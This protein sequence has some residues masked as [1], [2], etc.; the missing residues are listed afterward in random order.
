MAALP[1]TPYWARQYTRWF[2]ENCGKVTEQAAERAELLVSELVTNAVR[3]S[4]DPE[5]KP[6]SPQSDSERSDAGIVSLSLR[7]FPSGLLIEVRDGDDNPPVLSDVNG[8]AE[9]G[10]G[11]MLVDTLA[12]EWSY[13]FVADGGK[14]VYC[15]LAMP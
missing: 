12:T 1:I 14:V 6:P 11:L 8:H 15:F 5:R 13:F 3:F 10:R 9:N 4:G 7:Y 2:M